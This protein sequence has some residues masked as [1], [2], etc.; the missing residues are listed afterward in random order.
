M[1]K[2]EVILILLLSTFGAIE[3]KINDPTVKAKAHDRSLQSKDMKVKADS[4]NSCDP[5][6]KEKREVFRHNRFEVW[7]DPTCYTFTFERHC[8]C[9]DRGPFHI[10]VQNGRASA[11]TTVDVSRLTMRALFR[12]VRLSCFKDCPSSG[13]D[14]CNLEYGPNGNLESVN[15]D[16]IKA[17]YDEEN[18]YAVSNFTICKDP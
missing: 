12:E 13:A 5:K 18:I 10:T 15:I 16:R 8:R 2:I 14:E 4:S 7:T 17:A 9:M 3:G 6:W 1:T 11:N